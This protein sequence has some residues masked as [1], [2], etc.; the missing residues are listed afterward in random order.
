MMDPRQ[1]QVPGLRISQS[2]KR[3]MFTKH[4]PRLDKTQANQLGVLMKLCIVIAKEPLDLDEIK[5]Q[6]FAC[7]YSK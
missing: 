1:F 3:C 7:L 6:S 5:S 2:E 4:P